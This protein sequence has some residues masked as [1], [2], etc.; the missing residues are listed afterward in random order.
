[1]FFKIGVLANFAIFT[2]KHRCW[3]SLFNKVAGL[4]ACN[5]VKKRL[6][7]RCFPVI[8]AKFLKIL[9]WKNICERLAACAVDYFFNGENQ[10]IE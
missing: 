4:Q 9:I 2:G 3:K 8:T 10:V 7:H 6:Q 5:F 1:M